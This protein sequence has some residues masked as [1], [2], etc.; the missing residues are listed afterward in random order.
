M[1]FSPD[2]D[3]LLIQAAENGDVDQARS[4]LHEGTDPDD[5]GTF[6]STPLHHAAKRGQLEVVELLLEYG[7]N[8]NVKDTWELTPLHYAARDGQDG[9]VQ[10]LLEYRA[11]LEAETKDDKWRPLHFAAKG[12]S[13]NVVKLL[14]DFQANRGAEDDKG[15]PP[16]Y[17]IPPSGDF[18]SVKEWEELT[19]LLNDTDVPVISWPVSWKDMK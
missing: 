2:A 10:L 14:L 3:N 8:P 17:K 11:D 13:V 6:R 16:G 9:I 19:S 12:G 4:L 18:K 7:A 5:Q 1:E 15:E